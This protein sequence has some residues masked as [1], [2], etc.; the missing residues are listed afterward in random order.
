MARGDR[1]EGLI[2]WRYTQPSADVCGFGLGLGVVALFRRGG[3]AEQPRG[4]LLRPRGR[5][6]GLGLGRRLGL[7]LS[8]V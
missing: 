6:L 7:G 8:G 1:H 2:R 3:A 5:R 4:R